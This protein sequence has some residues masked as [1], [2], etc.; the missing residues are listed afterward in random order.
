MK[1]YKPVSPYR[2][3]GFFMPAQATFENLPLS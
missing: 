2:F 3:T 1:K